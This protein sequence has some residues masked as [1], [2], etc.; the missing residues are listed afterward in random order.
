M[1]YDKGLAIHAS[2]QDYV[3]RACARLGIA[4]AP[5]D[6]FEDD[7]QV[8]PLTRLVQ[9]HVSECQLAI[10]KYVLAHLDEFAD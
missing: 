9:Q 2:Q 1:A 3:A 7:E 6:A 4:P 5:P 8:N 10:G